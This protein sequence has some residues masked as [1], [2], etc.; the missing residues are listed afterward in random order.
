[1]S[2]AI[3]RWMLGAA[4]LVV[5]VGVG[6][7]SAEPSPAT[8]SPGSYAT[9][10]RGNAVSP[11]AGRDGM[12]RAQLRAEIRA[13]VTAAMG[14]PA[15]H[16]TDEVDGVDGVDEDEEAATPPEVELSAEAEELIA[17]AIRR[18]TWS[19]DDWR[20]LDDLA[21]RASPEEHFEASRRLAVAVNSGQVRIVAPPILGP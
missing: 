16:E 20:A 10:E 7:W 4:G 17:G 3:S 12:D 1:M 6:R 9:V 13:A 15:L 21:L 19:E 2:G 14:A 5:A 8:T 11:A 18:A